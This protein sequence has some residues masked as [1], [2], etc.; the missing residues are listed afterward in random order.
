MFSF[1][2]GMGPNGFFLA[3]HVWFEIPLFKVAAKKSFLPKIR[4]G[5]SLVLWFQF[6]EPKSWEGYQNVPS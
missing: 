3:K 1:K 2:M 4:L 6:Y 5:E